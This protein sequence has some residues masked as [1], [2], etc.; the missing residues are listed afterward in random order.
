MTKEI[1]ITT[2]DL[3]D[4]WKLGKLIGQKLKGDETIALCGELGSGK[5]S[6][7]QGLAQGLGITKAVTSPTFVLERIYRSP[8]T[9]HELHHFDL[10][11][12]GTDIRE[13]GLADSLGEVIT[14]IEWAEHI[15]NAL[16]DDTIWVEIQ[17]LTAATREFIFTIPASRQY[18]VSQI[19]Q[20][21]R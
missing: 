8:K 21:R 17:L 11:R 4:T 2:T 5:T 18:V 6:F 19:K 12:I 15:K 16:P 1:R 9:K 14:V 13:T 10:Y 3:P 7:T 20:K